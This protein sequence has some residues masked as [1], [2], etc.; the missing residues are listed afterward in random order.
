M[1]DQP[2]VV[3][4]ATGNVGAPLVQLLLGAGRSVRAI[5]KDVPR[6]RARLGSGPPDNSPNGLSFVHFDFGDPRTFPAAFAG[7]SR[8]FLLRPPEIAD[9]R[10]VINPAVNSAV[11]CGVHRIVFLS[12]QGAHRNP[13]VPHH[14]IERHLR[15]IS[16]DGT[17]AYSF[18]RASFFM[19]NL[20]TT[21]AM[22]I[23]DHSEL[24]IPA[25]RGRTAFVDA[26]DVAAAAAAVL[27]SDDPAVFRNRAY[28]LTSRDSLTYHEIAAILTRLLARP[29]RYREPGAVRFWRHMRAHGHNRRFVAVMLALYT[30]ARL[31]LAGRLS[32]ELETLISRPPSGFEQFAR[33]YARAWA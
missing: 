5:V 8:L 33:D 2:I 23:R 30:T 18:L 7:A 17:V 27:T 11:A 4:G 26:R 6:A 22:D 9:A 25:G 21:H 29:V 14:A 31:G 10:R 3:V 20:S 15:S 16:D 28:E 13:L 24:I 19:Q 32:S 12:I 1:N